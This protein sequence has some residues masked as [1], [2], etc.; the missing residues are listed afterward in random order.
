MN[1]ELIFVSIIAMFL[2]CSFSIGCK[3][4]INRRKLLE[5]QRPEF[6]AFNKEMIEAF[7]DVYIREHGFCKCPR[8]RGLTKITNSSYIKEGRVCYSVKC[9]MCNKLTEINQNEV[10]FTQ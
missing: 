4:S 6:N 9:N 10:F 1:I 8:C 3:R 7:G 2:I 5:S